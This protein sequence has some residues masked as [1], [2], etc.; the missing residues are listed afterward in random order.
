MDVEAP[1]DKRWNFYTWGKAM[2][3]YTY[4][5]AQDTAYQNYS[6]RLTGLWSLPKLFLGL[7]ATSTTTT[8]TSTTTTTTTTYNNNNNKNNN[9]K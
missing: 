1:D 4:K 2:I 7:N 5:L 9:N 6:G 3:N 8:T